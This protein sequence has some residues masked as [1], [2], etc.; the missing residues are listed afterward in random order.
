[1]GSTPICVHFVTFLKGDFKVNVTEFLD[2]IIKNEGVSLYLQK[3]KDQYSYN[4]SFSLASRK[5]R[6]SNLDYY[7]VSEWCSGGLEGGNCWGE[8]GHSAM[9]GEPEPEFDDLDIV[10]EL[11]CP[12]ITFLQYKKLLPKIIKTGERTSYEYYGN[13]TNYAIK[14]V[15][16]RELYDALEELKLI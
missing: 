10:L 9:N 4:T 12:D 3:N 11:F 5:S 1:M 15:S 13:Y 2:K 8:G 14:Y 16:L 6:K 7:L